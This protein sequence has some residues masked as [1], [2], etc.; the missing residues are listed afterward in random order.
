MALLVNVKKII[1]SMLCN[2]LDIQVKPFGPSFVILPDK[3]RHNIP[4]TSA[5]IAFAQ[6]TLT[7]TSSLPS[8]PTIGVADAGAMA[9]NSKQHRCR[10]AELYCPSLPAT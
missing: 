10:E 7:F 1:I 2:M 9:P 3:T 5:E 6:V 8:A 4:D